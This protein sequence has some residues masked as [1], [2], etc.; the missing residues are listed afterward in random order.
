VY[1]ADPLNEVPDAAPD[2][3]LLKVREFVV[4]PAPAPS[5]TV[6]PLI[7]AFK[8]LPVELYQRSPF[9]GVEG[10]LETE[11]TFS[12][13]TVAAGE[14]VFL[15]LNVCAVPSSATVSVAEGIVTPLKVVAVSV[16]NAPVFA[17]V[18]PMAPGVAHAVAPIAV[19]FVPSQKNVTGTFC[20]LITY[21]ELP[22]IVPPLVVPTVTVLD[23]ESVLTTVVYHPVKLD[24]G[25]RATVKAPE[26]A[27]A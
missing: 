25:G 16:V 3:P 2:P 23:P 11:P 24:A 1:G 19:Q 18:E 10:S 22:L 8:A 5:E 27:L 6:A 20:L 14:N 21:V 4:V 15:A 7:R 12:P 13:A 9:T 26:V 17:V